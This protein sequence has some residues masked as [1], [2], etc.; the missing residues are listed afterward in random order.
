MI[1]TVPSVHTV[2]SCRCQNCEL[3]SYYLSLEST[4]Q[5]KMNTKCVGSYFTSDA[6]YFR[7]AVKQ[8]YNKHNGVM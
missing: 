5:N 6:R 4:I 7:L 1:N 8:F 2:V 3:D